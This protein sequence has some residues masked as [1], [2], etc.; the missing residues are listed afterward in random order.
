MSRDELLPTLEAVLNS[1]GATMVQVD[2]II[3]VMLLRK[4]GKAGVAR[5]DRR[6]DPRAVGERT[7]VFPLRYVAPREMQHVL[8]K[9]LPAGQ[10]ITADDKRAHAAGAGHRRPNCSSPRRPS[11]SSTSTS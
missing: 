11:A 2:G 4:D 5:A 1:R 8:E 7:E 10:V 6:S 9:V 3:R